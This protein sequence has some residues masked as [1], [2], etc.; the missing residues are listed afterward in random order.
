MNGKKMYE[1]FP[2]FG[3]FFLKSELV[4]VHI[5]IVK[6]ALIPGSFQGLRQARHVSVS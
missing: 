6:K 3:K 5:Y 2:V 1:K 4:H